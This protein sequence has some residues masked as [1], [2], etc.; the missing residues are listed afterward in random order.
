MLLGHGWDE[1]VKEHW[2]LPSFTLRSD[3]CPKCPVPLGAVIASHPLVLKTNT[4]YSC[5][6]KAQRAAEP[7]CC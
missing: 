7:W 2:G 6:A 4:K 3:W 5:L 1:Q